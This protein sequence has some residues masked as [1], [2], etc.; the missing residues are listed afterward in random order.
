MNPAETKAGRLLQI[1]ALLLAHPEGLTQA[2]IARRLNVNRSTI[3]RYLPDLPENIY[4]DDLDSNRWKINRTAYLVNLRLNL[5]EATAVHLAARLLATRQDRDNPH[6][7][8]ALRKLSEAIQPVAPLIGRHLGLSADVMD[9]RGQRYDP[10]YLE[11]LENLTLAW[12]ES[13]NP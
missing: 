6:A 8:A 2:E 12:A 13:S 4:I 11:V 3:G 9:D 10:V 5:H 1:E 7:A